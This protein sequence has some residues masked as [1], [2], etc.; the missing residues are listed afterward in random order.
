MHDPEQEAAI[1]AATKAAEWHGDRED[2]TVTFERIVVEGDAGVACFVADEGRRMVVGL[3]RTRRHEWDALT[4]T[5]LGPDA[6]AA[7]SFRPSE[8]RAGHWTIIAAGLAPKRATG[9]SV[10]FAGKQHLVPVIEGVYLFAVAVE[11]EP[12]LERLP[13]TFVE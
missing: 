10:A 7:Q 2:L 5:V 12:E 8:E 1:T 4:S 3:E 6:P 13:V 9:A 11:G